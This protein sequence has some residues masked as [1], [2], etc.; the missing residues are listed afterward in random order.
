MR[1]YW[2]QQKPPLGVPADKGHILC[3]SSGLWLMNEGSG[4][5][6]AD[7]SLNGNNG[8]LVNSA[9]WVPDGV[10]LADS[11]S[12]FI[13]CGNK[14]SLNCTNIT[15]STWVTPISG[16]TYPGLFEKN[17]SYEAY[18]YLTHNRIYFRPYVSGA[19][20]EISTVGSDFTYGVENHI[21]F[22]YDGVTAKIYVNGV[23]KKSQDVGTP[24]PL[25][26]NT[27]SLLLGSVATGHKLDGTIHKLYIYNRALSASEISQLYRE[28]FCMFVDDMPVAMMYS[29]GAA[30]APTGQVILI[31]MSAV[32]IALMGLFWLRKRAA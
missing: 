10:Y 32:P 21:A 20:N 25:D 17:L 30:P 22:T 3:P 9:Y 31:Q 13:G 29:Y 19:S 7:L 8:T 4:N 5:T 12:D 23:L 18:I 15:V 26:V 28:P 1:R 24:G 6:V 14:A 2:G 27:N 16:D 11:T